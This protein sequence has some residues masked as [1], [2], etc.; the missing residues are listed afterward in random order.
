MGDMRCGHCSYG[1][2]LFPTMKL[3]E[4]M[5]Y[6]QR[7]TAA[8]RISQKST[9][10]LIKPEGIRYLSTFGNKDYKSVLRRLRESETTTAG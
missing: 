2:L 7:L 3:T 6:K 4:A 1:L 10:G 8:Q 5:L 9:L